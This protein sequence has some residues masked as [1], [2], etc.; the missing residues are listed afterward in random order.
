MHN[1]ALQII[2]VELVQTVQIKRTV[3][4]TE[5]QYWQDSYMQQRQKCK[6]IN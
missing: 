5:A 3:L 1:P 2:V 4:F 6:Y